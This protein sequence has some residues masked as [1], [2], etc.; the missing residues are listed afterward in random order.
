MINIQKNIPLAN[1]TTFRIG[2]PAKHFAEVSSEEDL[3]EALNFAKKNNLEF[4][5]LGG[6]SNLLVSDKGFDGIIIKLKAHPSLR[7][8]LKVTAQSFK[9]H[10]VKC[11]AGN[12]LAK[13][14]NFSAENN[15]TGLEWAAGI[16]GTI[17]GAVRGS[18]GAFNSDMSSIVESVKV[19]DISELMQNVNIKIQNNNAKFKIFKKEECNFKYRNSIFKE[20]PNLIILSVVLKLNPGNKDEIQNKIKEII[21]KRSLEHPKENSAGSFFKNPIV[22]NKELVEEFEREQ[23]I[24]YGDNKLPAGWLIE[25]AGLRGKKIGGAMASEKHANFIINTGATTAEDVIILASFIKQ[26][27]RDKFGIELQEE[28]QLIGF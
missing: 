8:K 7:T 21:K 4:F 22:E 5:I 16:P 11:W 6:G 28:V 18:A 27:V 20:N 12:S 10:H 1:Y 3:L 14:V 15:L 25:Q 19:A 17:G 23:G 26:Q 13:L 2:G 24:K 9:L